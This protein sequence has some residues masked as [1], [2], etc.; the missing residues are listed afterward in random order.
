MEIEIYTDGSLIRKGEKV[1]CGYS[2]YFPNGEYKP[3]SR[4]FKMEPITNNR[5]E[6]Y[7]IQKAI[8]I[9]CMINSENKLLIENEQNN[10]VKEVK[11]VNIYSD[12]EYVIKTLN[13]WYKK[14]QINKKEYKNADI[15]DYIV[16]LVNN[17]PFTINFIHVHSH[18]N[19]L[20]IH[21]IN[22]SIADNL[23]KKGALFRHPN[24]L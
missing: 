10:K 5:A 4:N 11:H 9:C 6:L 19:G 15:I 1:Y 24:E 12:S 8:V 18:T 16:N 7:A 22:N 20:D 14:W 21:S 17:V 13:I 2:V 3:I 23:A